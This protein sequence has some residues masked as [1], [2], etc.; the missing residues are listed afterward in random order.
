MLRTPR[1]LSRSAS[2][3]AVTTNKVLDT[4]QA[5]TLVLPLP[6]NLANSRLH[7]AARLREKRAY[8]ERLNVRRDAKLIAWPPHAIPPKA[9]VEIVMYVG[10]RMDRDNLYARVKWPLDWLVSWG[11]V[12]GDREDQIEL[13]VTQKVDRKNQRMS[14]TITA[15]E[16]HDAV[17]D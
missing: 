17:Q 12:S 16:G 1:S 14:V 2:V 5:L 15:M 3:K 8:W 9:S 4:E 6:L 11:Y 7:W 10:A 13:V